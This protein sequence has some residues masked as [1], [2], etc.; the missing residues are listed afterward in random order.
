MVEL[1]QFVEVLDQLCYILFTWNFLKFL[2]INWALTACC[3]VIYSLFT[4]NRMTINWLGN[5]DEGSTVKCLKPLT[6]QTMRSV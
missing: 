5:L 4:D 3:V 1:I 6:L 2:S